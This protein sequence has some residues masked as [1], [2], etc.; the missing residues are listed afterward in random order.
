MAGVGDEAHLGAVGLVDA[1]QHGVDGLG[2]GFQLLL[3]AGQVDAPVQMGG[4][5]LVQL[6]RQGLQLLRRHALHLVELGGGGGQLL[7][8]AE[9]LLNGAGVLEQVGHQ[10]GQ[11]ADEQHPGGKDEDG[12]GLGQ[13]QP[14]GVGSSPGIW[15]V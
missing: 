11:L 1:V 5:D 6:A 10:A 15:R 14:D 3:G 2:Q 12:C 13:I 8:G 9:Y 4:V 7:D